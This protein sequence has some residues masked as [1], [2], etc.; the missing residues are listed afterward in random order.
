VY[1]CVEM[2]G[3]MQVRDMV[4]QRESQLVVADVQ[5]GNIKI[6][7]TDLKHADMQVKRA[8]KRMSHILLSQDITAP[9]TGHLERK[10]PFA[11]AST[12]PR[13]PLG[14]PQKGESPTMEIIKI[15]FCMPAVIYVFLKTT[16]SLA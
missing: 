8:A 4:P 6:F 2:V 3:S 5:S 10:L 13:K 11:V 1:H 14:L 16:I 15:L 7:L 9:S 12:K